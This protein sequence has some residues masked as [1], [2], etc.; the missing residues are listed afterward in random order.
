MLG[1]EFFT[2]AVLFVVGVASALLFSYYIFTLK[3]KKRPNIYG[4]FFVLDYMS[5]SQCS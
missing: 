2:Y 4:S 3:V 1:K 5:F